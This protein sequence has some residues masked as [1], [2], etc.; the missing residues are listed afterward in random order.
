MI[1]LYAQN[2]NTQNQLV[3]QLSDLSVEA[4]HSDGTYSALIW[5]SNRKAPSY[6]PILSINNS[7]LPWTRNQ[8][9][10][11][12]QKHLLQ[13]SRYETASFI[14][15]A[16]KRLLVDLS[17]HE[18][19]SLTEKE[20]SFLAFLVQSRTHQATKEEVL[21]SVW[22]YSS[23]AETHTVE[24]HWYALKQKIGPHV[25]QLIYVKNGTFYLL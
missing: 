15:D 22:Q 3:D 25:N 18:S 8:W 1:G 4:Y 19:I 14:F 7:E 17:T 21:E 5:L 10:S 13:T 9:R 11:F 23:E 2:E 6:I 16:S 12:I 20:T 24:S